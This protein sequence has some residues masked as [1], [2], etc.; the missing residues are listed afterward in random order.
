MTE[1]I[2][3]CYSDYSIPIPPGYNWIAWDEDSSCY[4]F[5]DEPQRER[6][7]WD[8]EGH[9]KLLSSTLPPPEPG[10]LEK[11][12]YQLEDLINEMAD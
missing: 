7:A 12:C 4:L 8:S 6:I 11:Q 1:E 3:L 10:S 2:L 5:V 9:Y